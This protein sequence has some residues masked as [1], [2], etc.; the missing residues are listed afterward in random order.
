MLVNGKTPVTAQNTAT[1][2]KV[3]LV[4]LPNKAGLDVKSTGSDQS[5][6]TALT[7]N[8]DVLGINMSTQDLLKNQTINNPGKVIIKRSYNYVLWYYFN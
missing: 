5:V 8:M 2:P 6:P 1:T 4:N 3:P 7:K